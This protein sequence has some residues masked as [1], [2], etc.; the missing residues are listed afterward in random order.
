MQIPNEKKFEGKG[1]H[2]CAVCDGA[3]YNGKKIGVV[4]GGNSALEEA[5]FLTKF[6]EKVYLIRRYDYFNAEK[7]LMEEVLNNPKIEILKVYFN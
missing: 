1:V 6:A 7:M 2:Y 5:V 4:G 3:M